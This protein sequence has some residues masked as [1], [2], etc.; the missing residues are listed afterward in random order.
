MDL[1]CSNWCITLSAHRD[2]MVG[3]CIIC[4]RPLLEATNVNS[5]CQDRKKTKKELR[6]PVERCLVGYGSNHDGTCGT[7]R[8]LIK[9]K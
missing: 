4:V 8:M 2:V 7:S 6:K 3:P 1:S 9:N 5:F